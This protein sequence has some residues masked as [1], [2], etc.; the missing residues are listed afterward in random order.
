[1]GTYCSTTSLDAVMIGT[2]FDTATTAMATECISWAES[3]IN[4]Y[5]SKRYDTGAFNTSTSVPPMVRTWAVWLAEGYMYQQNSRGGKE[6]M[7]RGKIFIDRAIDNLKLVSEYKL[8]ILNSAGSALSELSTGSYRIQC[9]TLNYSNTF[10][11]D[12]ELSWRVS[13]NKEDDI[14]S[15]RDE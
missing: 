13:S 4:K 10:N 2:N 11:E 9:S 7:E 8:D 5:L 15:E 14:D 3:E 6:G 12:D 1:M